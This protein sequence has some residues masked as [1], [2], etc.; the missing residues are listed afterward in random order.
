MEEYTT[1]GYTTLAPVYDKLNNDIDYNRW[2]DY[3]VHQF[4][5]E[6]RGKGK[7]SL[8]LE[9]GCG[10]GSM[11]G[12]LSK[13]G[14]DMI[15]LDISEEMLSVAEE[16]LREEGIDSVLWLHE[17]MSQF[18]L[19]GTVDGVIS[20]LDGLNHL[21]GRNELADC[22]SHVAQYL[23][24]GGLFLFDVNTPAKFRTKYAENDYILEHE[25]AVLCWS[26]RLSKKGDTCDF[27]L[28]VFEKL[29]SGLYKRTDGVTRERCYGL[30]ALQNHAKAAGLTWV[31]CHG[32]WDGSEPTD[33]CERWY[34]TLR[35]E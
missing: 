32:A 33:T 27:Y 13:R 23:N 19:Y 2:A 35:K 8:L 28:T 16:K 7:P 12:T 10:T 15:A 26:N 29:P 11:T 31:S 5:T 22:F 1:D 14:F 24:P 6:F 17:S 20:C 9:L 34:I 3:I 25:D 21:T 18:E 30:R 4:E